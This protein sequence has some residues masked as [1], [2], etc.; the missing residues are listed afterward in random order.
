[1][2]STRSTHPDRRSRLQRLEDRHLLAGDF[3]IDSIA[4]SPEAAYLS[5]AVPVETLNA[6]QVVDPV[7]GSRPTEPGEGRLNI[8]IIPGLQLR[9]TPGALEAVQ[10]AADQWESHLFD[11]ITVSIEFDL[12]TAATGVLGFAIPTEVILPYTEV[13]AAM[14]VD[15]LREADDSILQR[16]PALDAIDF[17]LPPGTEFA[18]DVS[19]AKANAKAIGLRPGELDDLFGAA[20]GGIVLSDSVA[21]DFD[22]SDGIEPGQLDFETVVVHEI[23]HILGFLSSTDRFTAGVAPDTIAPTTLDLFRFRSLTGPDNPR[24]PAAF[25]TVRRELRPSTPAVIDFVL[26]DGWDLPAVEYPVELG[27]PANIVPTDPF[28][29]QASHWQD[30]D[31]FGET[32]GV[33]VPTI[34]PQTILPISNVDLR[35]MDLIGYDILPPNQTPQIPTLNDD[36]AFIG[37]ET[38]IVI[39]VLANDRND[40]L[41]FQLSAFRVVEPPALG[42]VEFDPVT[43]LVVYQLPPGRGD[44]IDAFAYTIANDQGIFGEPAVVTVTIAGVGRPPLAIDDF[45]LTR[46]NQAVVF[47]PLDNDIDDGELSLTN[48][49]LVTNPTNGTVTMTS[50]GLRYV[51]NAD[52]SGGDSLVYTIT[53][54][55]GLEDEALV[56]FSVGETLIPPVVPGQPLSLLQR[57]DVNRDRTLSAIDAL[58]VINVLSRQPVGSSGDSLEASHDVNDDG[59]VTSLDALV[60]INLLSQH[61]FDAQA[62]IASATSLDNDDEDHRLAAAEFSESD[63]LIF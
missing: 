31:L 54:A 32:I 8:E 14:Q 13:R 16:L 55:E 61:L 40:G 3:C 30:T 23:G 48:L 60:V 27:E 17:A 44:D 37:T 4:E 59:R 24:T 56:E 57:S 15:G 18:G 6:M 25:S 22:R 19:I 5:R 36:Q 43:G 47:N 9:S 7:G 49:R 62:G 21:F 28:G 52:Y 20:D 53:N 45:V 2:R 46:E 35:A 26:Q 63:R 12:G 10:R 41:P 34:P 39:D 33:L 29:Y 11:P 38:R 1:M 51:P 50:E 42:E 58:L